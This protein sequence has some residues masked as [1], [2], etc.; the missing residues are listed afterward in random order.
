MPRARMG[1]LLTRGPY[2]IRGYYR[3]E[4]HN[5]RA[6]TAGRL[7]PQRRLG[8]ALPSGHLVVSGRIKDLIN[9]AARRSP[10]KR[11]KTS[12]LAHPAVR[13]A[14]A[15]GVPDD[16]LGERICAVL[17]TDDGT[18][19]SL[20]ELRSFL[21]DRGLAPFKLPDQVT[22]VDTLPVTAVGKI[23]KRALA[24]TLSG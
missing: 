10:A 1:E 6:F 20:V 14:A 13:H 21:L 24:S 17:V 15:V 2:T 3:A 4:D 9:R 22:G 11:S 5:A 16:A 8:A 18:L 23:D 19:P 7:L 12:L